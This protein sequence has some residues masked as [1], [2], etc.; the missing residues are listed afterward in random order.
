MF[1]SLTQRRSSRAAA[2]TGWLLVVGGLPATSLAAEGLKASS[3][4]LGPTWSADRY[5]LQSGPLNIRLQLDLSAA[6]GSFARMTRVSLDY[7]LPDL[8]WVGPTEG[9][10][11]TTGLWITPQAGTLALQSQR[12]QGLSTGALPAP[13]WLASVQGAN[14]STNAAYMGLGYNTAW[15]KL[16]VSLSAEVGMLSQRPGQ[17]VRLGRVFT[18][19]DNLDDMLRDMHMSPLLELRALY[20]F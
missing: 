3:D 18:G 7:A 10:R 13:G 9:L 14:T 16:G 6:A 11:F 15:P 20:S 2:L 8:P 4:A 5:A 17:A 19:N 12:N 1:T